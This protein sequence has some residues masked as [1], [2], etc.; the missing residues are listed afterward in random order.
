[1]EIK[2]ALPEIGQSLFCYGA[3]VGRVKKAPSV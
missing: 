1:M 2:K 3:S